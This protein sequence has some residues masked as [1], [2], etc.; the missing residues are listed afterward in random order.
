MVVSFLSGWQVLDWRRRDSL[1]SV[2][3]VERFGGQHANVVELERRAA[4]MMKQCHT[5]L[6]E[7]RAI[8]RQK[9]GDQHTALLALIEQ[10]EDKLIQLHRSIFTKGGDQ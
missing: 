10:K 1:E 3:G 9:V 5:A 8:R 6:E 2:E 4:Q 7:L